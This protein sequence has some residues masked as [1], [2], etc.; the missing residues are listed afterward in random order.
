VAERPGAVLFRGG[1][2][3]QRC[4]RRANH[5]D[6]IHPVL[7]GGTD[8]PVNLQALCEACNLQKATS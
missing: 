1:Y 6:H 7:F 4:G 5:V 3:C 8:D 2:I